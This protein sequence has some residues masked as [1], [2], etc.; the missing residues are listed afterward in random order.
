[1]NYNAPHRTEQAHRI[2]EFAGYI[3]DI[4]CG[5]TLRCQGGGRRSRTLKQHRDGYIDDIEFQAEM[6]AI[7]LALRELDVPQMDG[8]KL[9]DI[10]TAGERL[11]GIAALW[12]VATPEERREMV[13]LMLEP[14]GLYY[15]LELKEIAA[16]RPRPAFLS[17]MR[18]MEGFIEYEEATG[19]LVTG[20]WRRRNRRASEYLQGYQRDRQTRSAT[21]SASCI[22]LFLLLAI[23]SRTDIP[24]SQHSVV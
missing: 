16:L 10:I 14:G 19:T 5:L 3:A 24:S 6:A 2:Y 8:L 15:D 1:M 22:F 9:D 18:L 20:R 13:L 21:F 17:L 12:E 7:E 11:P 4:Q 23:Y